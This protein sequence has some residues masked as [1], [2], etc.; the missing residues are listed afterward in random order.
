MQKEHI[1]HSISSGFWSLWI[2]LSILIPRHTKTDAGSVVP[3]RPC[4]ISSILGKRDDSIGVLSL[5]AGETRMADL[6]HGVQCPHHKA[7]HITL[8]LQKAM[9]WIPGVWETF[10]GVTLFVSLYLMRWSHGLSH[11]FTHIE[12]LDITTECQC[13]WHT[14]FLSL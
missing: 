4:S 13:P 14:L 10:S 9:L 6:N 3:S 5:T 7:C 8:P 11:F 12:D 1:C 2:G